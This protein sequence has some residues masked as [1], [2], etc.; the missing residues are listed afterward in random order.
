VAQIGYRDIELPGLYGLP[1]ADIKAA[2][3]QAGLIVSS[4]HLPATTLSGAAA[5]TLQSD[6]QQ[7]ADSLNALGVSQAIV[8]IA[9]FPAG[10]KFGG[11]QDDFQKTLA[12]AYAA[13][14]A[15]IWKQTAQLLNERA[16]AL[17]PLGIS[18]G[19]HNHNIEFAP[20]GATTGWDIIA[21]ETDPDLVKFEIDVGWLGAAGIDPAAFL[22]KYSGRV[23]WMH[24]KDL[25]STSPVNYALSMEPVEVGAGK[26]D[27]PDILAAADAAGVTHFYVE[28]EPPFEMPRMEA[29]TRSYQYLSQLRVGS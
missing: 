23:G 26:L 8:P 3:D 13:A 11:G 12:Q 2:A 7:V 18:V 21:Q 6:P 20:V 19:Y 16:A 24:V 15:D 17:K 29:I 1:P 10:L 27:W 28:Q 4:L 9:L 14:G 22:R 25:K 5:L